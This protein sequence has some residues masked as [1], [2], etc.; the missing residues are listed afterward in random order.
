MGTEIKMD[1]GCRK[2]NA[3]RSKQRN[4]GTRISFKREAKQEPRA[5]LN[6]GGWSVC[7][8]FVYMFPFLFFICPRKASSQGR[9][10]MTILSYLRMCLKRNSWKDDKTATLSCCEHREWIPF[11]A[12]SCYSAT[13]CSPGAQATVNMKLCLSLLAQVCQLKTYLFSS[14]KIRHSACPFPPQKGVN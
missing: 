7:L 3:N 11:N 13:W 12:Q 2:A 9:N 14:S 10:L 4:T 6:L 8:I 1:G 5:W